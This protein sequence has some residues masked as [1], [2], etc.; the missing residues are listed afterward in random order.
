M[1]GVTVVIPTYARMDLLAE[2]LQSLA[3]QTVAP[4]AVWV[5][6]DASPEDVNAV[7][8]Q[9]YPA[10]RV[11]RREVNGGFARAVNT[12][13][14]EVETPWVFLMNDD[15][16]LEPKCLAQLLSAAE[17]GAHML[18][19]LVLMKEDPDRVF[20]AG[21]RITVGGRPEAIGHRDVVAALSEEE[22]FG[23][24]AGA[25]LYR[26]E[27]FERIG[28]FDERFVAYFEDAD[29][30]FRAR[31]AGFRAVCVR[32]ARASHVGAA[33]IAERRWWRSRQCC[34]NHALLV[35]KNM[36]GPLFVKHFGALARERFHQ[37]GQLVSAVR[38]KR[39]LVGGLFE[40]IR[41]EIEIGMLLPSMLRER[42]RIQR[43]RTVSVD[44]IDRALKR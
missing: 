27:I 8:T 35:V 44:A 24:S 41:T 5:V 18:A 30:S 21:D 22:P 25:A 31:L 42:R 11:I 3:A 39:G 26:R 2:A 37:I 4:D 33:S 34:R 15:V 17:D 13:L 32:E 6:D 28:H 16:V 14:R 23:V 38:T 1:S 29:L 10:A 36:P 12:A 40:W 19:P 7:A 43:A 20:A 9:S